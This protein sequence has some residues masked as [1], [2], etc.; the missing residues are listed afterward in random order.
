MEQARVVLGLEEPPMQEE[1]LHFLD[2]RPGVSVLRA[3]GDGDRLARALREARPD[4]AVVS[5]SLAEA[6]VADARDGSSPPGRAGGEEGAVLLVVAP[7]E[8]TA[9]LR[10]ALRAGAL[11]FFLWPDEREALARAAEGAALRPRD[12]EAGGGRVVGVLGARGGAGATF[13]AT[14]LAAACAARGAPTVLVDLD[15][16]FADVTPA[17][18]L[19]DEDAPSIADLAPLAGELTAE[20]LEQVLHAHRGGFRVLLGPG[21]P[22]A[23]GVTPGLVGEVAGRLR[24]RFRA[25]VLHVPRLPDARALAGLEAADEILLVVTPDVLA[26]RDARRVLGFLRERG[27]AE[28]CRLVVNR[29]ARSEVVPRD[30]GRALGL[31]P[32]A[33]VGRDRAVPRAQDRGELLRRRRR[34]ARR[35]AGL[36]GRVLPEEAP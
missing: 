7:R 32:L 8:T 33:V 25:V 4:A 13:L 31:E 36:A 5:P 1:V 21:R 11:G 20:H 35:L 23:D 30:V 3:V 18:G 29:A 6:A 10:A 9:G 2:R 24:S 16:F 17:L 27:L 19:E 34:A 12:E 14:H 26:V 28:R 15:L 22:G